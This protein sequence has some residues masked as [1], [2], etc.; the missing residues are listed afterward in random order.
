MATQF[1]G[2]LFDLSDCEFSLLHQA[3][4][5]HA[6]GLTEADVTIQ[7]CWDADRLD[8]GRVGT[9]AAPGRLCTEAAKSPDIIRWADGRAAFE[10]TPDWVRTEWGIRMR[11][12]ED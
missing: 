11:S 6:D 12:H 2:R 8:L 1:R 9:A 7:T 5:E 4:A 3:C 10:L